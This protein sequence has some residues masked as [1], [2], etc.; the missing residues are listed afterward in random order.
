MVTIEIPTELR[1]YVVEKGSITVDGV[2][3][4]VV[5]PEVPVEGRGETL[6]ITVALIPHTLA[7]TTLGGRAVG[8]AVNLEIDVIAKYVERLLRPLE[9]AS[10]KEH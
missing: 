1:R 6:G 5:E 9:A 7:S 10:A 2:S 8:D 4:T 3:L